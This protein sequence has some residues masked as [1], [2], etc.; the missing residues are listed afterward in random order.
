[1]YHSNKWGPPPFFHSDTNPVIGHVLV[2][3]VGKTHIL[4]VTV[5]LIWWFLNILFFNFVPTP[6]KSLRFTR[7]RRSCVNRPAVV[8]INQCQSYT[9]SL[10]NNVFS[11]FHSGEEKALN[12]FPFYNINITI[13]PLH[14]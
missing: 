3:S 10:Q 4:V 12:V 5:E 13:L 9:A 11:E 14:I 6:N 1:M 7:F 8:L 2:Y